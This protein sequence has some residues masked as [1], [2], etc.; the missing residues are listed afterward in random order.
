METKTIKDIMIPLDKYPSIDHHACLFEAIEV[1]SDAS[2]DH[3]GCQSLPRNLL[4]F[5]D[6]NQLVGIVRR[7]DIMRVLEP[8][9]L[10]MRRMSY[11][12]K[13]F[14]IEE[15]VNLTEMFYDKIVTGMRE[16]SKLSIVEAMRPVEMWIDQSEHIGK[17]IYEVVGH[18][19]SILPVI[20]DKQVVGVVRTVDLLK[21]IHRLIKEEKCGE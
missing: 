5:D 4:V 7:R 14:D 10:S 12:K 19:I 17:A 1:M 2:I 16:K 11:K 8:K 6:I 9:F 21:E 13:L 3:D 15:D 20:H 18:N